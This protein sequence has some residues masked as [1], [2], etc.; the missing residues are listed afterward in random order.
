MSGEALAGYLRAQATE[1]LRSLRQHRENGTD[2][3]TSARAKPR[4]ESRVES[5]AESRDVSRDVS[6]AGEN[7]SGESVDAARALR[8]SARRISGTLH[9]FRPLLDAEWSEGMRPELAWLSGTLAREHA[10][11]ARLERLLG[12]LNRLS[13]AAGFPAQAAQ[14]TG[15]PSKGSLTVGAAKAGALLDRQLTLAR[16]RAHSAALQALG[17]SRFHA[18]ADSVA[19]LASEVPLTPAA[20][21][22]DLRPLAAAATDRLTDAVTALPLVT[23]GH[24]YNA[25]ALVHGLSA[26][27]AP[28]PQDAPW[29]QVRLL[30]R[31]HRYACEVLYGEDAPIDVRL[32]RAGQAL[33]R[34][35]D[36]AEAAAAAASAARTPRIAPATA[37]ALG[38][39]H[40]DQRHEVE[41]ARFAFQQNWQKETVRTP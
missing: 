25:E 19:V 16:T 35:R 8:R 29:H 38:V 30:L 17:S 32:L 37:Y 18:V 23:A 2:A 26:D 14:N 31:L 24:P 20:A 22:A 6:R 33:N 36:A 9:T 13:G 10:Y 40:A 28:H 1:F 7:G 5:R 27:T 39:L 15:A 21:T 34:H 4:A 41:A 3:G 12:A 11:A